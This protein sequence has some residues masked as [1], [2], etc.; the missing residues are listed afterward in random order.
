MPKYILRRL[1]YAI[2]TVLGVTALIFFIMRLLPGDP[3]AAL[4]GIEYVFRFTEEERVHMLDEL[5][6]DRPLF[7]QYVDWLRDIASGN[8]GHS[9][10]RADSVAE[11]IRV[12]GSVSVEIGVLAVALSWLIGI[13]VG[14]ASALRP[15]TIMDAAEDLGTNFVDTADI[16]VKGRSEETLGKALKGRWDRFVLAS[17]FSMHMGA[18][19]NDWGT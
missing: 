12:R 15:N 5:G 7:L 13:P 6:L 18:G 2:P 3:L 19:Q 14:I 1:L 11:L 9:F 10:F 17:K 4:F 16:Y 8:F